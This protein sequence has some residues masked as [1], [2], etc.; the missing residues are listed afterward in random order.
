[1]QQTD[2][3]EFDKQ[4]TVMMGGFPGYFLTPERLESYWRGLQKMP[5]SSVIRV[6]DFVLSEDGPKKI[7][8]VSEMWDTYRN[9]KARADNREKVAA[10]T[11]TITLSREQHLLHLRRMALTVA[12]RE[13]MPKFRDKIVW[14][15]Y[16]PPHAQEKNKAEWEAWA[17]SFE[18]QPDSYFWPRAKEL[19]RIWGEKRPEEVESLAA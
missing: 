11:T 19:M 5:M 10:G 2:R 17:A 4:I 9:L 3:P 18:H 14:Y 7:P 12:R 15:E 1:M 6:V 13:K 8:S 16:L